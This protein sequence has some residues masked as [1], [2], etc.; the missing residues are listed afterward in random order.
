MKMIRITIFAKMNQPTV[1]TF[2]EVL[3]E[4]DDAVDALRRLEQPG[5]LVVTDEFEVADDLS[6]GDLAKALVDRAAERELRE[7]D[8]SVLYFYHADYLPKIKEG[9][10][11]APMRPAPLAVGE[12]EPTLSQLAKHPAYR[13]QTIMVISEDGIL[14]TMKDGEMK[15]EQLAA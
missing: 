3:C 14:V 5:A 9:G 12:I 13:H 1:Q 7:A 8:M 2:A 4:N 15:R 10:I 6:D 11:V